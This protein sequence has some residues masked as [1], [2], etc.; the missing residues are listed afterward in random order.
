MGDAEKERRK[1]I[2]GETL[3]TLLRKKER[4]KRRGVEKVGGVRG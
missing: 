4:R 1:K 2:K 3:E